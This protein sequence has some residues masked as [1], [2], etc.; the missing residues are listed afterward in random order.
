MIPDAAFLPIYFLCMGAT[1]VVLFIV[2]LSKGLDLL[3]ALA[4]AV[5]YALYWPLT[6]IYFAFA[7]IHQV[8]RRRL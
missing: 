6:W 4:Y 3:T 8:A 5:G 2:S 1:L 7:G